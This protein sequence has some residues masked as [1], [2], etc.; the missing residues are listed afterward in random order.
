M[1]ILTFMLRSTT[2]R[3]LIREM[4]LTEQQIEMGAIRKA[5]EMVK[6]K[7]FK[8]VLDDTNEKVLKE[9]QKK[10]ELGAALDILKMIAQ[11]PEASAALEKGIKIEDLYAAAAKMNDKQKKINAL[12][13]QMTIDPEL[14]AILDK[15]VIDDF[16]KEMQN[17]VARL[18]DEA[19]LPN[20]DEQL[21]GYLK[22]MKGIRVTK[23]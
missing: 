16:T 6:G 9:P 19:F 21:D 5:M 10:E 2:L 13:D 4:L 11:A 7:K 8:E 17:R 20:T 14:S 23:G 22:K 15:S 12:W 3:H 1:S 18:P